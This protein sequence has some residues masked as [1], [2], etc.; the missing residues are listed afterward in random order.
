MVIDTFTFFLPNHTDPNLRSKNTFPIAIEGLKNSPCSR[1][2][3]DYFH[4][5]RT[6]DYQPHIP[7]EWPLA[8]NT[9]RRRSNGL[10]WG[11]CWRPQSSS[12]L[13][14][15]GFENRRTA[16]SITTRTCKSSPMSPF[17]SNNQVTYLE[18]HCL[19]LSAPAL[20]TL[21]R[22]DE[23][24]CRRCIQTAS[25]SPWQLLGILSLAQVGLIKPCLY[26]KLD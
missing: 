20:T 3:N 12:G 15:S 18:T 14:Q 1:F 17:D 22:V 19:S 13:L 7:T 16:H 2:L 11:L 6:N 25:P 9:L 5:G 4:A 24:W 23:R 26:V 10:A 21:R 8:Q